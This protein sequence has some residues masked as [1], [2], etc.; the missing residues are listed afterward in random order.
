MAQ[1][2]PQQMGLDGVP[3]EQGDTHLAVARDKA[4][5]WSRSG[6]T[7]AIASDGG[8]VIP[9]LGEGWESLYTH[10]FAGADADD[11]ERARRLLELMEPY[12]GAKAGSILDR[13]IGNRRSGPGVGVVGV[14]RR[15]GGHSRV[16]RRGYGRAGILGLFPLAHSEV[17]KA[18]QRFERIRVGVAGRSLDPAALL[19]AKVF[20]VRLCSSTRL[21]GQRVG[22]FGVAARCPS[23]R[24]AQVV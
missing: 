13:G 4:K 24:W 11:H 5:Q 14:A 6:S 1:V 19:G 22:Q 8:L 23:C 12:R 9:V 18:L 16:N 3:D 7:L 17:W 21:T 10:R 20:P 15:D 2:T